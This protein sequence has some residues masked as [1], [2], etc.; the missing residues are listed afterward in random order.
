MPWLLGFFCLL[1]FLT[2]L[3]VATEATTKVDWLLHDTWV[4]SGGG[5]VPDDVV[6]AAIDA[7]SLGEIGRWPWPRATIADLLEKLGDHDARAVVV[8]VLFAERAA[9][10]ADDKRIADAI[11]DWPMSILPV[12]T[13]RG[14]GEFSVELLPVP[15]I[16]RVVTDLGH[17]NLPIDDDGIVRRVFLMSGYKSAHWPALSLAALKNLDEAH[18]PLPD[19]YRRDTPGTEDWLKENEALIPFYGGSGSFKR[20]SVIDIMQGNLDKEQLA[21]KIVFLGLTTKGLGDVVPTP[22]SA[23]DRPMP[24]VEIHAN[25]FS[26]LRDNLMVEGLDPNL[27]FLV[28]LVLLSVMILV[29]SRASPEW[30]AVNAIVASMVPILISFLLYHYAR[31]WFAP[32]SSSVPILV[33][34][35]LWS[36]HRLKYINRFLEREHA[37]SELQHS[38]RQTD[39]NSS[40]IEFFESAHR[41]L[42]IKAWR[43]SAGKDIY[44]GGLLP[45]RR[46]AGGDDA[47][48]LKGNIY[49]RRYPGK[50]ALHIEFA[51]DDSAKGVEVTEL[52]DSLSRV[53]AREQATMFS[54][55][56]ERLQTNA[57][58]LSEQLEW[59]RSVKAFSDSMLAGSPTGFAVW[60]AAG[61]C[62]RANELTY[63]FVPEFKKFGELLEFVSCIVR[64]DSEQENAEHLHDLL[65][66]CEP[67]QVTYRREDCELIIN[68]RAVGDRLSKRLICASLVDVSD[69][70]SSERARAEMVDYL[71]HDLRSPLIS[72][73]YLLDKKD[74]PRIERNINKSLAM[75]DNLLH[76]ARADSLSEAQFQPVLLNAVLD[77]TLDQLLPQ[78][79]SQNIDFDINTDDDL[80]VRGDAA[81]LER[82]FTNIAGNAIKYSPENTTVTVRLYRND[83]Q[84]VLTI[85]D[86]G[87]GIQPD[88]LSKLFNRFK[89]DK[90]TAGEFKGIGLGL[91]LVSRVV[92]LHNGKVAASN[93]SDG[94]RITLQL[95][96]EENVVELTA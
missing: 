70:R 9:D 40:L 18:E 41:H 44:S 94:T 80:W 14:R 4:R 75:M 64:E 93:I 62:V 10:S 7:Q 48:A 92:N 1:L 85:D 27:S 45:A 46:V 51:I 23:L 87:V 3:L 30:G 57:Q 36:R 72:A 25:I 74:D 47:W 35:L 82:A 8:D 32:L 43:F 55:S 2:W 28:S 19:G 21:S 65:M 15:E 69:I 39:D 86:Q 56:I 59:L 52:I 68:F 22:V 11:A 53:R 76:V 58:T 91:A 24:G 63:Q 60:N 5:T 12:L 34:Y 49:A 13:E 6:I 37:K 71:S 16:T 17:I 20:V 96:L 90:S 33:S 66:N 81:S 84:A 77:N 61:E 26:A 38:R 29:Y 54:D 73:L 89:R 95:P 78:A 83:T 88:M 50:Q 79:L 67:W 42:P 31:L